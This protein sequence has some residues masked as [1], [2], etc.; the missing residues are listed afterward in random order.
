VVKLRFS[1][2][3]ETPETP[4]TLKNI[5]DRLGL[6]KE[7]IRQIQNKALGKLRVVAEDRFILS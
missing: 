7:R 2:G 1:I 4:L 5:G 6:T 3:K